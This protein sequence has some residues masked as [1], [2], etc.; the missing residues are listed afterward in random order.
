VS[1][2]GANALTYTGVSYEITQK[3]NVNDSVPFRV[4]VLRVDTR[5]V[6]LLANPSSEFDFAT[7]QWQDVMQRAG[8]R[9]T[10]G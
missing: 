9:A 7:D 2:D 8:V 4:A 3:T 10:Q 6:Y 5:I 1:G